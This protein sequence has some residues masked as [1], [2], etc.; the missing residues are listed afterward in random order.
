MTELIDK[1]GPCSKGSQ[2]QVLGYDEIIMSQQCT[3][4]ANRSQYGWHTQGIIHEGMLKSNVNTDEPS[5][6]KLAQMLFFTNY[7]ASET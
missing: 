2:R 5:L 3:C 7:L 6:H 4:S 1:T